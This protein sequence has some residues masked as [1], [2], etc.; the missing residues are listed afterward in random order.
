M[1]FGAMFFFILLLSSVY[2]K[3]DLGP[4]GI[5]NRVGAFFLLVMMCMFSNISA[6][7][8]FIQ[9]RAIYLNERANGCYRPGAYFWAKS[10]CDVVPL[11]V[12]PGVIFSACVYKMMGLRSGVEHFA[13]FTTTVL[14]TMLCAASMCLVLSSWIPVFAV[15]NLAVALLFILFMVTGGILINFSQLPSWLLPFKYVSVF[16]YA[17]EV[18]SVNELHGLTFTCGG[19]GGGASGGGGGA[20]GVCLTRGDDYLLVQGYPKYEDLWQNLLVLVA[21]FAG[22][23]CFTYWSLRKMKL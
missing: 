18:L 23:M 1:Q 17:M 15:A 5:Q 22:C 21:V 10:L 4:H 6:L 7:E 2:W 16:R 8:L 19:H 9:E 14:L 13:L 3:M 12:L 11:R 20:P